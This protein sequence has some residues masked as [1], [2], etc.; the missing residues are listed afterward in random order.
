M[1][2]LLVSM[3]EKSLRSIKREDEESEE[4]MKSREQETCEC[5]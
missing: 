5:I 2:G 4:E 1:N 3:L